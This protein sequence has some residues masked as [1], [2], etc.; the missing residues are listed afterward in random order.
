MTELKVF[1]E[2]LQQAWMSSCCLSTGPVEKGFQ[3]LE[4]G[5]EVSL[6]KTE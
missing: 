1:K 2:M 4:T 3:Q 5:D 6:V